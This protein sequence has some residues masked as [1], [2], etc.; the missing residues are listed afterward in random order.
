MNLSSQTLSKS[1]DDDILILLF[2]TVTQK[3]KD[4]SRLFND[5]ALGS[6]FECLLKNS[7]LQS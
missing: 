5:I 3:T 1:L 7:K 6:K 4:L 2:L